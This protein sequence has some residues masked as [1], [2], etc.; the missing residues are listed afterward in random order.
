MKSPKIILILLLWVAFACIMGCSAVGA[1]SVSNRAE[2]ERMFRRWA[3]LLRQDMDEV[4]EEAGLDPIS[5]A[6]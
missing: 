5:G 4:R 1:T 3:S 6:G 2:A